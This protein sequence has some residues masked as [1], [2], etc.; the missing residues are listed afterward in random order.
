MLKV[1]NI[2]IVNNSTNEA[3][4]T[5]TLR[6]SSP[7]NA[8]LG[9]NTTVT[10]TITDTLSTSVTTTLPSEVE[11]LTLTGTA[12]ING[13]GNAGNNI[14]NGNS[15][16]NTLIGGAGNDT[17]A[18]IANSA[19]GKDTISETT[20]GNIDTIDFTGTTL[21]VRVNLGITTE[22][23]VNSNLKLILSGNNVIENAQGGTGSDRLIGNGLNNLL[24]GNRG[25]DQLQGLGGDDSLWGGLGDD[26]LT[27]GAGQDRY[28]FQDSGAFTSALGV[29][30]ISNF[31]VGQDLIVLSKTTFTAITNSAGQT[32]TDFAVVADDDLVNGSSARIVYSQGSGGIFY[33]QDG[34]LLGADKV[35]EF[36]NLGNSDITLTGSNFSLIA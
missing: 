4:E 1:I 29:D 18:F 33:N 28:L 16:N 30:Y 11:N 15:A 14:L 26:I 35:F 19:L 12:A 7:T 23:T 13:T 3:D 34:N 24:I 6:L 2:P 20:T 31:E 27:G 25:N 36:A 32:L 22:Q 21:G 8:S 5:F 9:T 10:T 17:Y